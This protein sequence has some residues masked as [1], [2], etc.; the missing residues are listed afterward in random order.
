MEK[1]KVVIALGHRA[2]GTTLPEQKVATKNTAKK[3]VSL[4]KEGAELVITHGNAPQIGMIHT[5]MNEFAKG[6]PEYTC[7]PMSVCSAMSQGY[8]GFDLQ[9]AIRAELIKQGIYK[10]VCTV[11]TQV[12]VDPYDDAFAEPIKKI[13]RLL[14]EEEALF[15]EEKGNYVVKEKDGYRRIVAAPKPQKIVE[16]DSIQALLDAGNIVIACGGG[17]IPVLEQKAELK[18]AGAVIEKDYTCGIMAEELDADELLI[19]TSVHNVAVNYETEEEIILENISLADAKKYIEG[20]AFEENT[21]LPKMVA[22]ASF[23]EKR[24]GRRA[25]ITSIDKAYEG[26]MGQEGTIIS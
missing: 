4:V 7:A 23:V 17:G 3:I 2:M 26:Y 8:I 6:H 25:V 12:V 13:G 5:A 10:P 21:M 15:E 20:G 14:T 18:G 11:I 16:I 9:N 22:S 19:L 24:Q 1:K